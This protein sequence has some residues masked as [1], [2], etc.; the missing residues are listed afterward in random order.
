MYESDSEHMFET[1]GAQTFENF[2]FRNVRFRTCCVAFE[3][4]RSTSYQWLCSH[5]NSVEI[6]CLYIMESMFQVLFKIRTD[7]TYAR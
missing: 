4:V 5:M 3:G 6:K 7:M 2:L 1:L